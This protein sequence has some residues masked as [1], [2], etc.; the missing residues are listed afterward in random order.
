VRTEGRF[1]DPA[2][3]VELLGRRTK[4]ARKIPLM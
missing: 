3:Q 1:D 2:A 4:T